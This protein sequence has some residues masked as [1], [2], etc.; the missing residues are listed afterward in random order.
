[1]ITETGEPTGLSGRQLVEVAT[2]HL[3]EHHLGQSGEDGICP[4]PTEPG[5]F[6]QLAG[7]TTE[8]GV[9]HAPH[10]HPARERRKQGVE[11][12]PVAAEEPTDEGCDPWSLVA[13]VEG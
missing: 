12:P 8:P 7:E 1:F 10:V 11:R 9:R 3:D 2:K 5:L 4:G 6:G 13:D